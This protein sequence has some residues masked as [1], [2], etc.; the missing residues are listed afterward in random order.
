MVRPINQTL[1]VGLV[2]LPEEFK[3]TP[4][5]RCS[6]LYLCGEILLSYTFCVDHVSSCITIFVGDIV[7]NI[8]SIGSNAEFTYSFTVVGMKLGSHS[9][10]VGMESDKVELVTGKQQV[11]RVDDM[12][13]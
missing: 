8:G 2:S 1:I 11:C 12:I 6:F 7:K 3:G 13:M 10:V 5:S 4:I 9:L